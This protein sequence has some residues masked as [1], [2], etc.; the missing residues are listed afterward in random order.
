MP[1][2]GAFR[3]EPSAPR[4]DHGERPD[5]G[6]QPD[7]EAPPLPPVEGAVSARD[8]EMGKPA[9]MGDQA[10]PEA[11]AQSDVLGSQRAAVRVFREAEDA[12]ARAEAAAESAHGA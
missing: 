6:L 8:L 12:R 7:R 2:P 5:T 4:L 11:I 10:S 3:R 9:T 1:Q